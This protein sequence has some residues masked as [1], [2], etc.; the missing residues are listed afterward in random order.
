VGELGSVEGT[1]DLR[2]PREVTEEESAAVEGVLRDCAAG[3]G[4]Y[5]S[6]VRVWSG[7]WIRSKRWTRAW[8]SG[9]WPSILACKA[10]DQKFLGPFSSK[11]RK[12][13][14][15]NIVSRVVFLTTLSI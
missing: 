15:N 11:S 1:I 5:E 3:E 2:R 9:L 13:F 6:Q 8:K 12:G 7:V 14:L 10:Q 4:K